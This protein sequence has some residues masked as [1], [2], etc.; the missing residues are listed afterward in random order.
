VVALHDHALK[1]SSFV[2]VVAAECLGDTVIVAM[3]ERW[4]HANET[5]AGC[6]YKTVEPRQTEGDGKDGASH[7]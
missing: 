7:T 2:E 3:C 5:Y 4:S 1:K 6:R